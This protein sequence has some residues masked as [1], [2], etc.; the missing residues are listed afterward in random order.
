MSATKRGGTPLADLNGMFTGV[1]PA[2]HPWPIH[3]DRPRRRRPLAG[4]V[5][6]M[7]CALSG[8]DFL[9]QTERGHVFLKCADCG[10]ETPGWHIGTS[11]DA[12]AQR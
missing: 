7:W 9:F 3:G 1:F 4:V 12:Q 2:L 6:E 10:R 11:I 8:H 5:R